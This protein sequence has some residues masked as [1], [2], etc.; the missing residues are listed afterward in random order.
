[1]SETVLPQTDEQ[2]NSVKP[3]K[4]ARRNNNG[5][6]NPAIRRLAYRAGVKRLRNDVYDATRRVLDDYLNTVLKDASIVTELCKRKTVSAQDVDSG[7]KRF[8][9]TLYI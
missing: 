6:T 4:V 8:G 5:I 3:K 1:M 7:L 2:I 9:Q